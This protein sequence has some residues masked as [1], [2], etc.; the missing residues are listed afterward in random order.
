MTEHRDE[1]LNTIRENIG[2]KLQWKDYL[3]FV[4]DN[5][6]TILEMRLA[7][8]KEYTLKMVKLLSNN[9]ALTSQFLRKMNILLDKCDE[10]KTRYILPTNREYV[11]IKKHFIDKDV[12]VYLLS[13]IQGYVHNHKKVKTM[14]L[15]FGFEYQNN[16]VLIIIDKIAK[17]SPLMTGF[18]KIVGYK[19]K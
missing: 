17:G 16:V 11:K 5:I 12:N 19:E 8:C 2:R 7:E 1:W 3:S 14:N 6:D 9:F 13:N 15:V 18:I 10:V 4:I